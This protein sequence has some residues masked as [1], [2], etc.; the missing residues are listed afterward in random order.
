MLTTLSPFVSFDAGIPL[1]ATADYIERA[2]ARLKAA[3]PS[4]SHLFFG[5]PGDGNLHFTS[6]PHASEADQLKVDEIVYGLVAEIGGSISAEHGI[7]RIWKPFLPL[8]RGELELQLMARQKATLDP[9]QR[10]N[11][12]RMLSS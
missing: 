4:A 3:F 11:T 7:G 9:T 12:G 5:H 10:L 8:S 1:R 6:G 2:H